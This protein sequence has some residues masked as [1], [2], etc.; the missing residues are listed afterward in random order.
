MW[1]IGMLK[2]KAKSVLKGFYWK[3]VVVSLIVGLLAG[4]SGGS[5]GRGPSQSDI[6][7]FKESIFQVT[8]TPEPSISFDTYIENEDGSRDYSYNSDESSGALEN[9]FQSI[10]DDPTLSDSEKAYGIASAFSAITGIVMAIV[11]IAMILAIIYAIFVAQPIRVGQ[12]KFY[13]ESRR[14]NSNIVNVFAQFRSGNYLNTVKTQFMVSLEVFLWSLLFIIPGIVKSYELFLVPFIV[15]ENPQIDYKRAKE[16]SRKT[17]E[18]EKF[19]LW[20]LQLSFIGWYL[21]GA[22]IIIGGLFVEPYCN[23]TM[24]EFYC[25]MKQRALASGIA[26]STELFDDFDG[27]DAPYSQSSASYPGQNAYQQT[28]RPTYQPK[29]PTYQPQQPPKTA[30]GPAAMDEISIDDLYKNESDDNNNGPEIQ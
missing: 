24:T 12:W 22:I 10:Y 15:A 20:V 3:A 16:I 14:G 19:N 30:E 25:C 9:Y 7:D 8:E 11:I 6:D 2:E 4:S 17:M 27:M 26:D 1:T 13:L 18:G 28:Y 23:A 29:K 5:V 21:L